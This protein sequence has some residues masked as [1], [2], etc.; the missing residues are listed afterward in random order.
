M[1][2]TGLLEGKPVELLEGEIIEM[3][4]EGVPHS[5][6][7][8][9]VANYLRQLLQ[10]QA[11]ISEAHPVTLDNSEPEPDIAVLHLPDTQYATHHPYPQDICWLVEI[12]DRTLKK[13]LEE[14]SITYARNGIAEYWIIDLP[15]QKLWVLTQPENNRYKNCSELNTGRI[16]PVAFPNIDVEV[17]KLPIV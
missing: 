14:K 5:F 8:R 7:N 6:T 12:A 15:H 13:D 1:I 9:S 16:T 10:D 4:P 17:D 2:E 11:P 3:S